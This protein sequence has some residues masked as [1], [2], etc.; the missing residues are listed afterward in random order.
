MLSAHACSINKFMAKFHANTKFLNSACCVFKSWTVFLAEAKYFDQHCC[1]ISSYSSSLCSAIKARLAYV[2][3]ESCSRS[4]YLQRK[5]KMRK[6]EFLPKSVSCF[7]K[8]VL[9]VVCWIRSKQVFLFL[10]SFM[11]NFHSKA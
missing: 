10:F 7:N 3:S 8:R 6:S 9:G 4:N 11:K 5:N 1:A 2:L